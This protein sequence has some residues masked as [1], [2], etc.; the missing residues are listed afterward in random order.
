MAFT[1]GSRLCRPA[2]L[3]GPSDRLQ[4]QPWFKHVLQTHCSEKGRSMLPIA[5]L[6]NHFPDVHGLQDMDN[7]ASSELCDLPQAGP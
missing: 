7:L 5:A 4:A 1:Q 3:A 2:A 6:V